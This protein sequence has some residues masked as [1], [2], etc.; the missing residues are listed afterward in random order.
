MKHSDIQSNRVTV[1]Q[2]YS[3]CIPGLFVASLPYIVRARKGSATLCE[4]PNNGGKKIVETG[5]E[6]M[7]SHS[8][9]SAD[10]HESTSQI[11]F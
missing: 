8:F 10:A 4:G 6:P 11:Y 1:W 3:F 7:A 2:N 9:A 5:V